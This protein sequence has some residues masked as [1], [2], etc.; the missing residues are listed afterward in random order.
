MGP[1][2]MPMEYRT[3]SLVGETSA[4]TLMKVKAKAV[5]GAYS[6]A[7]EALFRQHYRRLVGALYVACG[8]RELA[9]DAVQ[10]A[11]VELWV[12]WGRIGK[13][14]RPS[15]WVARVAVNRLR[16]YRRSLRRRAAALL[17][18]ER[19]P[20]GVVEQADPPSDVAALLRQLPLRQRLA[21]V[22]Y[23]IDDRSV[24]DVAEIMG[25]S[26]GAVNSHL[27]RAREA[28]RPLLEAH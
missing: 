5:N 21:A 12:N 16:S 19:E 20:Q 11:F 1:K 18:L 4:R 2:A 17:R 27:H 25:I 3:E 23:Y 26:E 8:D 9:A 28:L 14:D 24:S 6:P 7:F 22:L 13:Y 10:Q 15:A